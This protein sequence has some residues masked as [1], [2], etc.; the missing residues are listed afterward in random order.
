M[1][2]DGCVFLKE[3]KK[4]VKYKYMS[5][6]FEEIIFVEICERIHTLRGT[7]RHTYIDLAKQ[8]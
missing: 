2:T 4:S 3:T 6:E 5:E 8:Q 7:Y 1:K